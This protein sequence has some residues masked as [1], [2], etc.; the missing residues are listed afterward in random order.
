VILA[1]RAKTVDGPYR[2]LAQGREEGIICN[3]ME[4]AQGCSAAS[5]CQNS[6]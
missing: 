5:Y 4:A 1:T 2:R 6:C 3:M